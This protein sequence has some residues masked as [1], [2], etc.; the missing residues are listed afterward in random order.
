[1]T[2]LARKHR[3]RPESLAEHAELA[4]ELQN[5]SGAAPTSM[6]CNAR[7]PTPKCGFVQPAPS[8]L[9]NAA[10]PRKF[11]RDVSKHLDGLGMTGGTL[12]WFHRFEHEGGLESVDYHIVTNPIPGG[13]ARADCIGRR[14][15]TYQSRDSGRRRGKIEVTGTDSR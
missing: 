2:E 3:V 5:A 14:T 6:R 15:F 7:S 9:Q 13:T 8:C 1:M 12:I 11:A 10:A 4:A